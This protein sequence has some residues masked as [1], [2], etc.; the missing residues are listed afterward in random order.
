MSRKRIQLRSRIDR[1]VLLSIKDKYVNKIKNRKKRYEYRTDGFTKAFDIGFISV[2]DSDVT[3]SVI[4]EVISIIAGLPDRIWELTGEHSGWINKDDFDEYFK[5]NIKQNKKGYAIKIGRV[6]CCEP[7]KSKEVLDVIPNSKHVY[8]EDV[9]KK[10]SKV[11]MKACP[12][13]D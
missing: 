12:R 13:V 7:F 2:T 8:V 1:G 11:A 6:C 10:L 5:E 3:V 9:N 4:F